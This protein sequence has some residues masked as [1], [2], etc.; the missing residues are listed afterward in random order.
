VKKFFLALY[1]QLITAVP[2]LK[3]V[4]MWNNQIQ[5]LFEGRMEMYGHPAVF[6]EFVSSDIFQGGENVQIYDP[7]YFRVHIAFW[8]IDGAG[9]ITENYID[10]AFEQNL[11][12]FD[13]KDKIYLALQK[14]Q[15]GIDDED[16]PA[17]ACVRVSENQDYSHAGVYH[18][19]MTFKT[20]LVDKI[21]QEPI[22]GIDFDPSPMPAEL[23]TFV[24]DG[25]VANQ[26]HI[27]AIYTPPA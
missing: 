22:N 21:S 3:Y 8:Q 9:G 2:E 17:G 1:T 18:F 26:P 10:G 12:I 16:V 24:T 20:T 4:R 19:I 15:P 11:D 23:Q 13:L 6:I 27:S 25:D 5:M 14:F 7:L